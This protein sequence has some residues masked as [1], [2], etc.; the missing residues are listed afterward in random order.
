MHEVSAWPL[1]V[2]ELAMTTL[3]ANTVWSSGEKKEE[4]LACVGLFQIH[5]CQRGGVSAIYFINS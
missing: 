5:N 1:K 2:F 4:F 3:T